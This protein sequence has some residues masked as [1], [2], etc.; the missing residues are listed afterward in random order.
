MSD[1][2]LARYWNARVLASHLPLCPPLQPMVVPVEKFFN[3]TLD[4]ILYDLNSDNIDK[5]LF[6]NVDE[7]LLDDP[8]D[9]WGY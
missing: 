8:R 1:T 5:D 9:E 4:A 7:M 6:R 2:G 3:I